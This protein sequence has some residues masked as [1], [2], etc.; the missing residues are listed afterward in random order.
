M[1]V[2][3]HPDRPLADG[4]T[5]AEHLAA[6]GVYRTQ[7]ETG[8]SNGGLGGDRPRWEQR[9]F[10]DS[11]SR[12]VYGALNLAG[13]PDGAAPR[14]GSCHLELRSHCLDRATFSL[15]DSHT[16]P[17]I[18]GTAGTFAAVWEGLRAQVTRTGNALGVSASSADAWVA[19]LGAPR[20]RAGRTLDDYVEAQV[21]DGLTLSV[22]VAAVVA[23][24][25]FR[26][27]PYEGHLRALGVPLRWHGGFRLPAGELPDALRGPEAAAL[28]RTI[29]ARYGEPVL[30]AAVLGRAARDGE[31]PQLVKYLWHVL[32]IMGRPA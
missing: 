11:G 3:F 26:G 22:D 15:G 9:M 5:V 16:E 30:D 6:D 2:N 24:P 12:P 31:H 10:G 8:I 7:Y 18:L 28:G 29:A 14:F 1:T 21:H 17:E 27:T 4:R 19:A 25:A 32:V 13:H 23:D 20:T